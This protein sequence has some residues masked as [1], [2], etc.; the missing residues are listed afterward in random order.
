MP[1]IQIQTFESYFKITVFQIV[2]FKSSNLI[3]KMSLNAPKTHL[4]NAPI[5]P[6]I[7]LSFSV[8]DVIS[9]AFPLFCALVWCGDC[10]WQP[11]F[12]EIKIL[13]NGCTTRV[14]A[15]F[16]PPSSRDCYVQKMC[17]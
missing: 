1:R 11:V 8:V 4:S 10:W 5:N 13:E 17:V 16:Q 12:E 9:L 7:Q 2:Q 14:F 6:K 15:A 3:S